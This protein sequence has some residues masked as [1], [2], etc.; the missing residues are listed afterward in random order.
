MTLF[1]YSDERFADVQLL[2]FQL[3]G[4]EQLSLQQKRLI[5]YLSQAYDD[6]GFYSLDKI[7][8]EFLIH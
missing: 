7:I 5:Y 2:R 4:F 6:L 8:K 1:N 3:A